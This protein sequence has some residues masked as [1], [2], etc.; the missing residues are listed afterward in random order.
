[1]SQDTLKSQKVDGKV[2][3]TYVWY[4]LFLFIRTIGLGMLLMLGIFIYQL[5]TMINYEY[6]DSGILYAEEF[7]YDG[8]VRNIDIYL[9][10]EVHAKYLSNDLTPKQMGLYEGYIT[11]MDASNINSEGAQRT[12]YLYEL[13]YTWDGL[14]FGVIM[15]VAS[16]V[17]LWFACCHFYYGL[18]F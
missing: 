6:T 13:R 5:N 7:G 11:L 1:M 12:S 17:C 3:G 16:A 10:D 15:F 9:F 2:E 14:F 8:D 18:K 4:N